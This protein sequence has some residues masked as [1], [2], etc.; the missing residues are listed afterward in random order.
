MQDIYTNCTKE[1]TEKIIENNL[2]ENIIKGLNNDLEHAD[3]SVESAKQSRSQEVEILHQSISNLKNT[4]ASLQK[5]YDDAL[6]KILSQS[7]TINDLEA[8]IEDYQYISQRNL[9]G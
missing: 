8:K 2:K 3:N 9:R 7:T 4:L 6:G 5:Q 1:L